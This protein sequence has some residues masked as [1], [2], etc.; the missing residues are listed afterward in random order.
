[1]NQ[2]T[3]SLDEHEGVQE[4]LRRRALTMESLESVLYTNG[5]VFTAAGRSW[6]DA[7]LVVGERIAYVGDAQTARRVAGADTREVDLQ[8]RLVVPGFVDAHAHVLM[9]GQ[10]LMQLDLMTADS[11]DEIQQRTARWAADNADAPRLR[12]TAWKHSAL[13]GGKPS[14]QMLDEIVSNKPVYAQAYDFHSMWLNSAALAELGI[15]ANTPQVPGGEIH[16]DPVT[17]EPTGYIDETAMHRY[18]WPRLVAFETTSDHDEQR[19]VALEAYRSLGITGATEMAMDENILESFMR[20]EAAGALTTR[21]TAHWIVRMD[22]DPNV[23]R[24]RVERA[25]ELFRSHQSKLL[26]VVGIKC[27]IDGTV[28]GCTAALGTPYANGHVADPS[29]TLDA[30]APVVELA[31]EAGMQVAMHAIGDEAIRI[32]IE[33]VEAAVRANGPRVRRHRIEH[34]EVVNPEE[35]ERLAALGITASMQPVHADPKIQD[36]WRAMLGDSR[37]D[38]GFPW[39]EM[40]DAGATLAFGT[41]APTAPL[42]PLRN[43]YVAA[44]RRSTFDPELEANVA[45]YALPLADAVRHATRDAAWACGSDGYTGE[46]SAGLLADFVVID[47]NIFD[48]P[49]EELLEA[50]VVQTV[51]GGRTVFEA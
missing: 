15:D 5:I 1:M 43:M 22:P 39:P 48:R 47:R 40:T 32:A 33:A 24:S 10:S 17:G 26:R 2:G 13:P 36:N 19:D 42:S 29:W 38:R 41:D 51:L 35:I 25:I 6:A 34:L 7:M 3:E 11:L 21:L 8:G 18:V 46:L 20:A 37:I 23:V 14:K 44:T 31:D 16:L 9:T 50:R 4:G 27:V 30:L 28:D 45:R 49:V 12:L